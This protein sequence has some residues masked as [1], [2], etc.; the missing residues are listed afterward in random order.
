MKRLTKVVLAVPAVLAMAFAALIYVGD[1]GIPFVEGDRITRTGQ[2]EGFRVGMTRDE[3]FAALTA[4]YRKRD[5]HIRY[6]WKR[7]SDSA[8]ALLPFEHPESRSWGSNPYAH[9]DEAIDALTT[10]PLPLE[11]GERWDIKLPATWVNSV[12]VTFKDDRVAEIQRSRWV[13]E[14]P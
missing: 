10:M 5:A 7:D 2:A 9:Y 12:Y 8:G 1:A 3:A 14:R 6:V 11:L 4:H 13:F